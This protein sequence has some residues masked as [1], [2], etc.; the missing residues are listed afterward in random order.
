MIMDNN[1]KSGITRGVAIQSLVNT[2]NK[3]NDFIK[4][5]ANIC[6]IENPNNIFILE[7]LANSTKQPSQ[8]ILNLIF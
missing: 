3:H 4:E 7:P 6:N 5:I 2:E 8:Y 1:K